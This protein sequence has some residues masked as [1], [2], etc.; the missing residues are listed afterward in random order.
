MGEVKNLI[1]GLYISAWLVPEE[2][3]GR[4]G[5]GTDLLIALKLAITLLF[6]LKGAF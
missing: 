2:V 5:F 6:P 4:K 3:K 1:V